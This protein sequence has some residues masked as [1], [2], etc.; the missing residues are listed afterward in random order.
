MKEVFYRH[1]PTGIIVSRTKIK[2]MDTKYIF[3]SHRQYIHGTLTLDDSSIVEFKY[4][5]EDI[6]LNDDWEVYDCDYTERFS[7]SDLQMLQHLLLNSIED[8]VLTS[9]SRVVKICNTLRD[10][11]GRRGMRDPDYAKLVR[12]EWHEQN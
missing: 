6:P 8:T 10:I 3:L 11:E 9:E 7:Y 4:R 1:K 5:Y 2:S 12:G